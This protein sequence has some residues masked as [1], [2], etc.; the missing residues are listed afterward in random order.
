MVGVYGGC[1][2][3]VLSMMMVGGQLKSTVI[4]GAQKWLIVDCGLKRW[5]MVPTAVDGSG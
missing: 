5:L 4:N 1:F 2:Y 3:S